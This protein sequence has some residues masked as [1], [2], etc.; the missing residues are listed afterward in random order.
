MDRSVA[1]ADFIDLLFE[2]VRED[3]KAEAVAS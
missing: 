3:E 1:K 2:S